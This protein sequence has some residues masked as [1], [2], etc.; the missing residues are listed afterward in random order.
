MNCQVIIPM[1]STSLNIRWTEGPLAALDGRHLSHWIE[2][3]QS[4]SLGT[5]LIYCAKSSLPRPSGR[6]PPKHVVRASKGGKLFAW[7]TICI[8]SIN[9]WFARHF[10]NIKKMRR[11]ATQTFEH[12]VLQQILLCGQPLDLPAADNKHHPPPREAVAMFETTCD[13]GCE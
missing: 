8:P 7:R 4:F 12:C 9:R 11:Q 10:G 6:T 5:P 3:P 2:G 1:R 13:D